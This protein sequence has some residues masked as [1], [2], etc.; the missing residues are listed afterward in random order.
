MRTDCEYPSDL[1]D[2]QWKI[3]RQLLPGWSGWGR[4]P[5]CRRRVINA[6]LYIARTGCQWRQLP[7]EFPHWKTVYL[8][9]KAISHSHRE[10]DPTP[11][12][13]YV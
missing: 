6:N 12:N 1:S 7:H 2:R 13:G 9:C 5:S 3:I 11:M 10:P 8:K 4:R